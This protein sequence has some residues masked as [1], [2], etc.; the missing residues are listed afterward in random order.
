MKK[1]D[2][3]NQ[4]ARTRVSRALPD[5]RRKN[6]WEKKG[7]TLT[8]LMAM[9]VLAAGCDVHA[10]AGRLPEIT[11]LETSLQP[12]VSTGEDVLKVL[13]EPFGKG[14][15]KLPLGLKVRTLWSYYYDED[16]ITDD[17]RKFLFVFLDEDIYD[18]YMWF[19]SLKK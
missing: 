16:T 3:G 9:M 5:G 15:E 8:C 14:K 1:G 12:G 13:G 18:G 7:I 11:P 4:R 10:R 17:R 2:K 6:S 19:S